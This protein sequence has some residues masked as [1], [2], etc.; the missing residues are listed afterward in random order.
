MNWRYAVGAGAVALVGVGGAL[1][2]WLTSDSSLAADERAVVEQVDSGEHVDPEAAARFI[3]ENMAVLLSKDVAEEADGSRLA[4]LFEGALS[5]DARDGVF[6]SVVFAAGEE[7]AIHSPEVR[8]VVGDAA[9][10][11]LAWF[12]SQISAPFLHS[13][14]ERHDEV[15]RSYQRARDFLDEAMRDPAVAERLRQSVAAYGLAEVA[16]APDAGEARGSRLAEIGRLQEVFT[17]AHHAAE[18]REAR[19]DGNVDA[20]EDAREAYQERLGEDAVNHAR[21]VAL[22]RLASDPAVRAE[23]AGEP[24]VDASGALKRDLTASETEA[25]DAWATNQGRE[26]GVIF[27]DVGSIQRGV[28]QV[29]SSG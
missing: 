11:H 10:A 28:G 25:L 14:A 13:N 23:A 16:A 3:D 4:S 8:A 1:A 20:V 7:G 21:W 17:E 5:S 27:D 29:V 9:A 24:F 26:G 12:D 15:R 22:D 6:E 18:V 19:L 2:M